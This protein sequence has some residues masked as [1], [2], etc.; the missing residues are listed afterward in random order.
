LKDFCVDKTLQQ[1]LG[2]EFP[3]VV[4][5]RCAHHKGMVARGIPTFDF[6]VTVVKNSHLSI[7]GVRAKRI[8]YFREKSLDF[9]I[10]ETDYEL[11]RVVKSS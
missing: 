1:R 9:L 10:Q 5:G 7:N 6:E 3:L 4:A 11:E 8:N 2:I